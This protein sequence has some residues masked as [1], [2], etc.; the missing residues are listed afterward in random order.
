MVAGRAAQKPR[1]AFNV[2]KRGGQIDTTADLE[3][4]DGLVIFVLGQKSAAEQPAE[5]GPLEQRRGPE[6]LV[7]AGDR[8]EH[9]LVADRQG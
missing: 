8:V 4:S 3:G 2:G 6:H 7:D 9:V 5:P 1:L